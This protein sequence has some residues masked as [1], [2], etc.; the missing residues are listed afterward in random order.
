MLLLGFDKSIQLLV[1]GS[2]GVY[3]PIEKR[4]IVC[5]G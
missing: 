4:D 1:K 3:F 5:S 2:N